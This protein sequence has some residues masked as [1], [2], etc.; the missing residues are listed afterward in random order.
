MKETRRNYK[1]KQCTLSKEKNTY[2]VKPLTLVAIY[3]FSVLFLFFCIHLSA[4]QSI[5]TLFLSICLS[6]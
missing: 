5:L 4:Y 3:V 2:L 6:F 1:E